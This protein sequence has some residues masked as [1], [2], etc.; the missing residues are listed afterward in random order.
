MFLIL[1][2]IEPPISLALFFEKKSHQVSQAGL[3]VA[4]L[5]P[6]AS[7]KLGLQACVT[8]SLVVFFPL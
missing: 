6:Q 7:E 1:L 8:A 2:G 3:E 5:M 4:N